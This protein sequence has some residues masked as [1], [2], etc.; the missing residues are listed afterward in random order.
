M[1]GTHWQ[2]RWTLL[3]VAAVGAS[4]A[5]AQGTRAE[6]L[7]H[8]PPPPT[9][10][11][12]CE[13][14]SS[15]SKTP[16]D[17]QR[18]RARDLAENGRQA[19]ILGDRTAALQQLID[20]GALDPTDA[21]LAYQL[22]RAYEAS[23]AG[24]KAGKE[25]CRFLSIA[26][27]APEAAEARERVAALVPPTPSASS[28]AAT[29]SFLAGVTAFEQAQM[30]EAE[31]KFGGAITAEPTWADAYY[32]RALARVATGD[33]AQAVSDFEEYLRLKPQADDRA[34]VVAWIESLR[35][36]PLSAGEALGLGVL[37]PGGGQFYTRRPIRG[38]LLL[39]GAGGAV[40]YGIQTRTTSKN[41][42]QTGIDPFGNPYTFTTTVRSTDRPNLIPGVAVAGAIALTSA[43]E[44]YVF[45]RNSEG[46]VQRISMSAAPTRDGFVARVSLLIR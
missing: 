14:P 30:T 28:A 4:R 3:F 10:R 15:T 37:I 33:H 40:G 29:T 31:S 13:A 7:K 27:N 42:Q 19:A 46:T 38:I 11:Q 39:A 26:P 36:R 12:A 16:T 1:I 24:V 18:R 34:Q 45:A 22:A 2:S 32:D 20:A 44:A 9:T 43:I 25:Y 41:V 21:D 8:V 17:E 5:S 23:G 6:T 35:R